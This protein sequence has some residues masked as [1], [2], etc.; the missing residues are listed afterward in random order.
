VKSMLHHRLLWPILILVILLIATR[1][2]TPTFFDVRV[3]N[4]NLFGSLI[5][6]L[7]NTAPTLLVALGM[8]LVVATRGVDLSVGAVAA[9]AG[10]AATV[11]IQGSD[12]PDQVV[13]VLAA[14]GIGLGLALLAGA[15]NGFLVTVVGI[16]PIIATLVLMMAGR[17]VAQLITD[18]QIITASSRPYK[19]IGGGYWLGLPFSIILAGAVFVAV[20]L[21]TRRTALGMLLE[22][23]GV[24]PEA[25]R[26]AGVRSRSIT[27]TVY[28][29]C[30]VC[31]GLAGLMITSNATAADP[32][33]TG[34]FIEMDAILAVVIGGTSLAGGRFSLAGTAIGAFIIQTMTTMI[35]TLGIAPQITLVYK[36]ALVTMVC[37]I[38]SPEARALVARTATGGR[39]VAVAPPPAADTDRIGREPPDGG[40][41]PGSDEGMADIDAAELVGLTTQIRTES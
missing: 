28:I 15:W 11:F 23:V 21:L 31:A 14:V 25:S 8:T 4:G 39:S 24:N 12:H 32:N 2:K 5:N 36:A 17:G 33:S 19:M 9:I 29:F 20:A 27:W 13:T 41:T 6:I 22:S 35:L 34:L 26:L 10:A 30:G 1:L 7:R 40:A 18:E 16:Q 38:Q 3:V 37:L